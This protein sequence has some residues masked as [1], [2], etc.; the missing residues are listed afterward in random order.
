[1]SFYTYVILSQKTGN[2]YKGHSSNLSNRL[3]QH[4][5]GKTRST[6]NGAPWNLIYFEVF[7]TRIEAIQREKYFK[8]SS[9]RRFLQSLELGAILEVPCPTDT[10]PT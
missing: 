5:A 10:E 1:M 3:K 4:N 9:G 6:K 7:P 2:M 8:T